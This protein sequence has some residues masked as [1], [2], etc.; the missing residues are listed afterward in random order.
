MNGG[1]NSSQNNSPAASSLAGFSTP[2][3]AVQSL[4]PSFQPAPPSLPNAEPPTLADFSFL[5]SNRQPP[6]SDSDYVPWRSY[7]NPLSAALADYPPLPAAQAAPAVRAWDEDAAFEARK[8]QWEGA[9]GRQTQWRREAGEVRSTG[10]GMGRT[11]SDPGRLAKA[12]GLGGGLAPLTQGVAVAVAAERPA[13]P[14][15]AVTTADLH[16]DPYASFRPTSIAASDFALLSSDAYQGFC[17]AGPP[18]AAWPPAPRPNPTLPSSSTTSSASSLV[19]ST[20]SSASP[21]PSTA[22]SSASDGAEGEAERARTA[23][24]VRTRR[25][26]GEQ[27]AGG[28][29]PA[30]KKRRASEG[31][32]PVKTAVPPPGN[33]PGAPVSPTTEIRGLSGSMSNVHL[34]APARPSVR[35]PRHPSA[36]S[37]RSATA[38][39][40]PSSASAPHITS[41]SAPSATRPGKQRAASH[42]GP[43]ARA[44]SSGAAPDGPGVGAGADVDFAGLLAGG[45]PDWVKVREAVFRMAG[46]AGALAELVPGMEGGGGEREVGGGEGEAEAEGMGRCEVCEKEDS[47]DD[48]VSWWP[49]AHL[50]VRI[51][52]TARMSTA[53]Q[54]CNTRLRRAPPPNRRVHGLPPAAHHR[55]R[56]PRRHDRH[57]VR[58]PSPPLQLTM[59]PADR[60]RC[61]SRSCPLTRC[62]SP[63]AFADVH[64]LA[65][66]AVWLRYIA[67]QDS[68]SKRRR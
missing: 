43:H 32:G 52:L 46:E 47:L 38:A 33:V 17:S 54:T 65:E 48:F 19:S 42:G 31:L 21:S 9:H 16:A 56:R 15:Q 28:A 37:L 18:T 64:R 8:R 35:L 66:P 4:L 63:F 62:C 40:A 68:Q 27:D 50:F 20:T 29:R 41:T 23:I 25:A 58:A 5:S 67:L 49:G 45:K 24:P 60:P 39:S 51:P 44:A 53:R 57:H 55:R 14:A 13:M 36:A 61:G 1:H 11:W 59:P 22:P 3:E 30:A 12:A 7:H 6:P 26:D 34:G 2:L 10:M